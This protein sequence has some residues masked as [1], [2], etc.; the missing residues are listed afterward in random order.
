[1]V[2]QNTHTA[3]HIFMV[4]DDEDD[5]M[6]FSD[7]LR[8]ADNSIVLTEVE[9]GKKLMDLLDNPPLPHLVFLDLN[10]PVKDGFECLEQIRKQAKLK[11]LNIV[12]YTTSD[13]PETIRKAQHLGATFYAV[14]PCSMENLRTLINTILDMD[15]LTLRPES[16]SFRL[17]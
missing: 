5:R 11:Q 17:I 9:N 2:S 14:K 16:R 4:D 8:S 6:I 15:W 12:V 7:I 10:M 13:N 3:R 1:M